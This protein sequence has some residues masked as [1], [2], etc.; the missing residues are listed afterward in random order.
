MKAR[1]RKKS[2][3]LPSPKAFQHNLRVARAV[4]EILE[5]YHVP[6][7]VPLIRIVL[8]MKHA[9]ERWQKEGPQVLNKPGEMD[10]CVAEFLSWEVEGD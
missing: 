10:S 5:T 7:G 9:V 6:T 1:R 2:P 4:L 8:S 3:P